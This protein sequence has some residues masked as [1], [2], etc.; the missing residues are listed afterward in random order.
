VA[1]PK[2]AALSQVLGVRDGAKKDAKTEI[3]G[4]YKLAQRTG[5]FDGFRRTFSPESE[6]ETGQP[7]GWEPDQVKTVQA[8]AGE[9]VDAVREPWARLL[10]LTATIDAANCEAKA[11]IVLPGG[12][13]L[14][15]GVPAVTLLALEH[16]IEDLLTFL[17]K[18]PTL[19]PAEVWHLNTAVDLYESDPAFTFKT[20]KVEKGL[21][22]VPATDK[23]PAQ[24]KTTTADVRVGTWRTVKH[25]GAMKAEEVR[26]MI[27]R[28]RQLQDAVRDARARANTH[29]APTVQLGAALLDYVLA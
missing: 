9:L 29:P 2:T 4:A 1:A 5:P 27:D 12:T 21:I 26:E 20:V 15:S 14:A 3:D 13:V 17:R 7:I 18:L 24:A 22:V 6:T 8:R 28:A 25:S 19:D 23:H 16:Q 10:D 11:D